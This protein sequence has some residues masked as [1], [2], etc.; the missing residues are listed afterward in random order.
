METYGSSIDSDGVLILDEDLVTL[1]REPRGQ[2]TYIG[3]LA[4]ELRNKWVR[5]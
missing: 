3:S 5:K 4:L 1:E 2:N